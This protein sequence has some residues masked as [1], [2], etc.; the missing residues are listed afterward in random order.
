MHSTAIEKRTVDENGLTLF[1]LARGWGEL[2]R[3]T[4]AMKLLTAWPHIVDASARL[5]REG[6]SAV[7]D[8]PIGGGKVKLVTYT[9]SRRPSHP[10]LK[11]P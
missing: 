3:H 8:V 9:G 10:P 4:Q 5:G 1:L 11:R 7:F 2:E 6:L